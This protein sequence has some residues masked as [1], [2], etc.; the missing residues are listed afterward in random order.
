[1]S[2]SIVIDGNDVTD[3][4]EMEDA[5][6]AGDAMVLG[7]ARGE[8]PGG[9]GEVDGAAKVATWLSHNTDNM[10]K[11]D[12]HNSDNMDKTDGGQVLTRKTSGGSVRRSECSTS[13]GRGE[14]K[15]GGSSRKKNKKMSVTSILS[16]TSSHDPY[17]Q[18]MHHDSVDRWAI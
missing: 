9:E 4:H 2:A 14:I 7:E 11:T 3:G 12:G 18:L 8:D 17:I 6:A 13:P 15:R 16:S 1:M 5:V 10:D